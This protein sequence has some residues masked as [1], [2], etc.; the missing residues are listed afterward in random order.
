MALHTHCDARED[1]HTPAHVKTPYGCPRIYAHAVT[2]QSFL[3]VSLSCH[4][5]SLQGMVATKFPLHLLQRGASASENVCVCRLS[6]KR[7][8]CFPN[9]SISLPLPE[10]GQATRFV[11]ERSEKDTKQVRVRYS[12]KRAGQSLALS[13]ACS[14]GTECRESSSR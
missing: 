14:Y 1:I 10:S 8:L 11:C 12:R 6:Q 4:H 9:L 2:H 7:K 5:I 3:R 13:F